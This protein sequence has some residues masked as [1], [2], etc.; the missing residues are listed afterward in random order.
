[1]ASRALALLMEGND[2][3]NLARLRAQLGELQLQL[4]PPQVD[5]ARTNLERARDEMV[6]SSATDADVAMADVRIAQT[7]LLAGDPAIALDLAKDAEASAG[8][9]AIA[10]AESLVVQGQSLAAMGRDAEAHSAYLNAMHMLTAAG[11][12][13]PVAQLW[14]ELAGLLEEAG[15]FDGAREAYRN[16]AAT[17]G[18]TSRRVKARQMP[19]G[20]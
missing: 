17:T 14:F 2:A 13:R 7:H 1:M 18:L 15:D 5:E 3:R 8:S 4:D 9:A 6:A 16:A 10:K 12:D 20:L 11:A 19:A